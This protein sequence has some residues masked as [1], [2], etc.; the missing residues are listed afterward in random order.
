MKNIDKYLYEKEIT[1]LRKENARLIMR[2]E[3]A[4]KYQKE[5]KQINEEL[6]KLKA[7]YKDKIKKLRNLEKS[8]QDFRDSLD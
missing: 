4:E 3:R 6:K 1:L 7:E 2:C 8:L 5:S